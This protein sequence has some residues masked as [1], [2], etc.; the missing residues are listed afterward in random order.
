MSPVP[1]M[2]SAAEQ[3]IS[4]GVAVGRVVC[5][6]GHRIINIVN[7]R[8]GLVT[9]VVRTESQDLAITSDNRVDRD[10]RPHL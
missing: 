10:Q 5:K 9:Q 3:N 8:A 1:G 2:T 7:E 4:V 6:S